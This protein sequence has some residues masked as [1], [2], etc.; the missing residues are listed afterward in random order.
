MS[1]SYQVLAA[2]IRQ[3][4]VDLEQVIERVQRAMVAARSDEKSSELFL[5]AAALNLHDFYTGLERIF[6][7]IA[8][9]I[10]KSLPSGREWHR[11]LLNQMSLVLPQVR[12]QVLLAETAGALREFLGFRHVVRHLY[13]FDLEAERVELL[14]SKLPITFSQTRNELLEFA[15]FLEQVEEE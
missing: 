5:D 1:S 8:T 14:I 9:T 2:R 10:D 11:E 7:Q 4:L 15:H 6:E 3:E 13:A 12:P